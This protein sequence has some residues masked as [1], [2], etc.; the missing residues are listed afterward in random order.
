MHAAMKSLPQ[1]TIGDVDIQWDI[2]KGTFIFFGLPSVTFWINPS[3]MT[4]LQPLAEEVGYDLFR[5]QVAASASMGTE[6]DYHNIV[7]VLGD[8]FEEGFLK[9]GEATAV[10]GW[11]HVELISFSAE[12]KRARVKISNTWELLMQQELP[13]RWGCP[14]IQGKI[15]GLFSHAFGVTCWADE[16]ACSYDPNNRFVEFEVYECTTTISEEI[17]RTRAERQA[18]KER[19]LEEEI[20]KKT[21][22]LDEA[23]IRAESANYAK[24]K[25]LSS[26]SHEFLTPLNAIIGFSDLLL[27]DNHNPLTQEQSD[28]AR[29]VLDAGNNMLSLVNQVLRFSD[30][31]HNTREWT[32]SLFRWHP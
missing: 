4:M 22:E 2:D 19:Q 26:M 1:V 30:V 28:M 7:T 11:G 27:Q 29:Q 10:A 8:S 18:E 16:V 17:D 25:F 32:V 13:N 23:R 24:S 21:R 9:W 5:L 12:K 14:F 20:L 3:L 15:I 31:S 6:E